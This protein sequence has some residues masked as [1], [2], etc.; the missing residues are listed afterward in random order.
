MTKVAIPSISSLPA[1]I[2]RVLSP[3]RDA[4]VSLANDQQ[5]QQIVI[6]TL[7]EL[8][9]GAHATRPVNS[10]PTTLPPV[11]KY[12]VRPFDSYIAFYLDASVMAAGYVT[13]LWRGIGEGSTSTSAQ[14]VQDTTRLALEDHPP[15]GETYRYWLR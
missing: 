11:S 10:S 2:Q 4:L 3:M 9:R 5:Q 6:T 13:E 12:T 1:P 14:L 7:Q 8:L 15:P